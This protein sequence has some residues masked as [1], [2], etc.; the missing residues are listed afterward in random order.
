VSVFT[1]EQALS[2]AAELLA[3]R[4]IGA[5]FCI[6]AGTIVEAENA[7]AHSDLDLVVLFPELK[8]AYRESLLHRSMPVEAF[9]HD[10]ETIQAF[11]DRDHRNAH[12]VII[13]MIA[14]GTVVGGSTETSRRLQKYARSLLDSGPEKS[15]APK[16]K[17]LRYAASEL[18]EDLRDKRPPHEVRAILYSLYNSLSELRLRQ[19]R[20]YIATG[21]HLA[22]A[23]WACDPSFAETL[24]RV[25]VAG[26]A[27]RIG[28]EQIAQLVALLDTLGGQLFDGYRQ[29]APAEMREKTRWH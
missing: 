10:H 16:M 3:E 4:Y 6:A 14:T 25:M 8:C 27:A 29:D 9:V 20:S 26:H 13:H 5:E 21:K 18:I 17:A 22:R 12:P 7:T 28:C 19:S 2:Y 11:M 24:D 1:S 15:A 23:L